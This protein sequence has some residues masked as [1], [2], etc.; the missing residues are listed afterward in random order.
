MLVLILGLRPRQKLSCMIGPE[1]Y[2]QAPAPPSGS[3]LFLPNN[4]KFDKHFLP[5]VLKLGISI[6][7]P[8]FKQYSSKD[9]FHKLIFDIDK[10]VD[11]DIFDST[12]LIDFLFPKRMIEKE[13][14][15][16]A[17]PLLRF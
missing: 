10:T 14:T 15:I 2:T 3:R 6:P 8:D 11:F 5:V 7:I 17:V 16:M 9:N 13:E 4:K 1:A 12:I